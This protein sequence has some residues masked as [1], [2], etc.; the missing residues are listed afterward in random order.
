MVLHPSNI[1][2]VT[3]SNPSVKNFLFHFKFHLN[4]TSLFCGK[5]NS[6]KDK[7]AALAKEKK[8]ARVLQTYELEKKMV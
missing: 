8:E 2:A 6:D 3:F 5:V 4:F 7:I 1:L